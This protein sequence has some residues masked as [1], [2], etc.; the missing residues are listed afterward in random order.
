MQITCCYHCE[1]RHLGCHVI[2]PKYKEQRKQLDEYNEYIK[3]KHFEE[4][5]VL[6]VKKKD[7][8]SF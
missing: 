6:E 2:C 4:S 5:L 7:L 1:V 8:C 3:R